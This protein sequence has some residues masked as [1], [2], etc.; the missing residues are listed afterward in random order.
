MNTL[1]NRHSK[2]LLTM[3]AAALALSTAL[4]AQSRRT[5]AG[6]VHPLANPQHDRGALD[7][8]ARLHRM[9]LFLKRSPS[10]QWELDQLTEKQQDLTSPLYHQW[11]TPEQFADRFGAP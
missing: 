1:L 4:Q 5:I 3:I 7:G 6:H 11:L 2:S 8:G 9:T 10:Q